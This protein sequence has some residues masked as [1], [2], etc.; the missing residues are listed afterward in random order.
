MNN[1]VSTPMAQQVI[2]GKKR[3]N[4]TDIVDL[5]GVLKNS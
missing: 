2:V 5:I 4:T 3:L 1:G